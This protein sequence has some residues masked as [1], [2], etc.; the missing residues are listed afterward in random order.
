MSI[1]ALIEKKNDLITRSEELTNAAETEGRDLTEDELK[2]VE[3][4][5]EEVRSIER[6]LNARN[7][8]KA[9]AKEVETRADEPAEAKEETQEE[10]DTRAFA[11]HIRELYGAMNTREDLKPLTKGA[12]GAVVPQ[13]IANKIIRKVYDICPIAER[14]T[15]YEYNGTLN[16]PKYTEDDTNYINVGFQGAEFAEIE[17]NSGKFTSISLT[18]FVAGA[19]VLIS[20][21][22]I[23]A[24]DFDLVGYVIDQMAY[25]V[26]RFLERVLLNGSGVISGQTG[27]VEGLTGVTLNVEAA[28]TNAITANELIDVQDKVKDE[29]QE[30]AIWIMSPATRAA[31]RKLKDNYGRYLLN[32]NVANAFGRELLGKPVFVSDNMPDM[33][34]GKVA[35]YYGDLSGLALKFTKNLEIQVLREKYA[36]S[37][38]DGINAWFSFDSK[39]E[40]AQKIAKLTMKAS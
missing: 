3:N 33:E 15:K 24:S 14:A 9:M 1:K 36:T 7:A 5:A 6:Q 17:A 25:S 37:Y 30:N 23:N 21:Q 22:L 31:I 10:A 16:I 32:E 38:A 40:N 4:N 29:F 35:I 39:V 18:D 34:A 26:K 27:T 13:T 12:N 28:A 19:L 8:V 2:E 11:A 20:R